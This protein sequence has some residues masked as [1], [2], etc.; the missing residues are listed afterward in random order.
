MLGCHRW[1]RWHRW[2]APATA[3]A[4]AVAGPGGAST[5]GAVA[6]T[7]PVLA[8]V[9]V[10]R[11]KMPNEG[12]H[13]LHLT[14]YA[15]VVLAFLHHGAGSQVLSGTLVRTWWLAQLVVVL[16]AAVTFRVGLPLL[17]SA[18][19]ELQV[20]GVTRE[21]CD[22]VSVAVAGGDLERLGARGG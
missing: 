1:H 21:S 13:L 15:A 8:S 6:G 20:T 11:R 9:W 10:V 22:V 17:R 12:W 19:Q 2:L 3:A 4:P 14:T 16:A 5:L 18:R 7:A